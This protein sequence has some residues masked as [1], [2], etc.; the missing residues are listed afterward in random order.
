VFLFLPGKHGT[1]MVVCFENNRLAYN[2]FKKISYLPV[3]CFVFTFLYPLPNGKWSAPAGLSLFSV[4]RH[5]RNS[6]RLDAIRKITLIEGKTAKLIESLINNNADLVGDPIKI[7]EGSLMPDTYHFSRGMNRSIIIDMA[8]KNFEKKL[9]TLRSKYQ[10]CN[11][12]NCELITLASIVQRE[13]AKKDEMIKV[14]RVFLNRLER[15]MPLCSD[16]TVLYAMQQ[17][18]KKLFDTKIDSP[19]NTYVMRG[20]TIGPICMPGVQ[21]IEAVLI[22]FERE[23]PYYY[24]C[25][26]GKKLLLGET[27]NDH[28]KNREEVSAYL[29]KKEQEKK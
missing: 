21:A 16:A 28:L 26:A 10:Q 3:A 23:S 6:E 9:N 20:L 11:L 5:F 4:L 19:Y 13:C 25:Y 22:A 24:F 27:H 1:E 8:R 7:E 2:S 12:T 18:D 15:N 14:A 17:L 29:R